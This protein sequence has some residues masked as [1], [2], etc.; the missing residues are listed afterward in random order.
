MGPTV[1]FDSIE[2]NIQA[3]GELMICGFFQLLISRCKIHILIT[4][5]A[6]IPMLM[7][8]EAKR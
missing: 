4:A 2:L 7:P 8:I 6:N 5:D 3:H 1:R